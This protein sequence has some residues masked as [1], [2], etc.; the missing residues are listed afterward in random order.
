MQKFWSGFAQGHWGLHHAGWS[1]WHQHTLHAQILAGKCESWCGLKHM[2]NLNGWDRSLTPVRHVH[3][4]LMFSRFLR[5]ELM[6]QR[7][8]MN[9]F[10]A[11]QTTA[12]GWGHLIRV[13]SYCVRVK[14]E[15]KYLKDSQM[16][17]VHISILLHHSGTV[18]GII[19]GMMLF[20]SFHF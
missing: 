2:V 19:R 14:S 13:R 16:I 11:Y 9:L 6:S 20:Q 17:S 7:K 12:A 10:T 8:F 3:W 15:I 5:R 4:C 1:L 18:P